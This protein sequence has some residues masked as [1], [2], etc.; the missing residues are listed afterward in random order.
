MFKRFLLPLLA[1]LALAAPACA[2]PPVWVVR[3]ADSQIILFGSVHLLPP[4]L[5]WRPEALDAALKSADDLWFEMPLGATESREAAQLWYAKGV[6]PEGEKLSDKLSPRGRKRLAEAAERAHLDMQAVD[7]MRPWLAEVMLSIALL[8]GEG[9]NGSDG[10]ERTIDALAPKSAERRAF[11]TSDQQLLYFAEAPE[12]EQ[13]A[14]LENSLKDDQKPGGFGKLVSAWMAAD[15]KALSRLGLEPMR[16][17]TPVLYSRL[18]TERNARWA[19]QIAE[20]LAGSGETV[21]VVGAAHLIGKDGV[22][23]M[24]RRRGIAVQGP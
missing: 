8:S 1:G 19:D 3:D 16:K 24:L 18:V 17:R 15:L 6:L 21:M 23:A 4:G 14:S 11:E 22:P 2:K 13:I 20:R 12:S 9:A 7:R 5:D 10:V